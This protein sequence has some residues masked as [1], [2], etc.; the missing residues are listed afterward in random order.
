LNFEDEEEEDERGRFDEVANKVRDAAN[1][2]RL[3]ANGRY[4]VKR[5]RGFDG[6]SLD[7]GHAQDDQ[8]DD[9]ACVPS[10]FVLEKGATGH[11]CRPSTV[12][13]WRAALDGDT[14]IHKGSEQVS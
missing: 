6:E 5:W 7:A 2:P 12:S 9:F 11:E 8:A 10:I 13:W 14:L 4:S 3:N 1:E